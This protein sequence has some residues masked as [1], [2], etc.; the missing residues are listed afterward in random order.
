MKAS[1][2]LFCCVV[3]LAGCSQAIN[4][5]YSKKNFTSA[6]FDADLSECKRHPSSVTAHQAAHR[7]LPEAQVRDCMKD[8]GYRIEAEVK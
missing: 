3:M 4:Y 2:V 7:E 8:K 5:T 6:L 1:C